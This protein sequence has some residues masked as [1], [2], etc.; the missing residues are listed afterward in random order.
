MKILF[1]TNLGFMKWSI[2]GVDELLNEL[3]ILSEIKEAGCIAKN[4]PES[5]QITEYQKSKY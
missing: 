3:L 1:Y 5:I 2:V 4:T